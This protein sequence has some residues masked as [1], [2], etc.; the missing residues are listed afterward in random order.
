[1]IILRK[2]KMRSFRGV[3]NLIIPHI[4]MGPLIQNRTNQ[5][6][7]KKKQTKVYLGLVHSLTLRPHFWNGNGSVM[8]WRNIGHLEII[9]C[10]FDQASYSQQVRSD[11]NQ[12]R[13]QLQLVEAFD[14]D[15]SWKFVIRRQL[16]A[17]FCR[18]FIIS[19]MVRRKLITWTVG[20][21]K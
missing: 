18:D 5:L 16:E 10:N 8:G 13:R 17:S 14:V 15:F 4:R 7:L 3:E 12:G 21:Q 20:P 11:T 2:K 6:K 9:Q 19:F 1:M